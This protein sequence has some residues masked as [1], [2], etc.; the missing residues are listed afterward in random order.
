MT[1]FIPLHQSSAAATATK[2]KLAEG[3]GGD[4][5]KSRG[6]RR[7]RPRKSSG[8]C[9]RP[10][11]P[12]PRSGNTLPDR[13]PLSPHQPQ[14]HIL[15]PS[16]GTSFPTIE[17]PAGR[18]AGCPFGL[19]TT[20]TDGWWK[21]MLFEE[22]EKD[23]SSFLFLLPGAR[24]G[25]SICC[26]PPTLPPGPRS[27]SPRGRRGRGGRGTTICSK[28]ISGNGRGARGGEGGGERAQQNDEEEGG[29]RVRPTM[30]DDAIPGEGG[31]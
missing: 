26:P 15:S 27:A 7:P 25:C 11:M 5:S 2:T 3:D 31:T 17:W 9:V 21:R 4:E 13:S 23:P 30:D 24:P 10:S 12:P 8:L 16:G 1:K 28:T 6:C 14:Q 22:E 18:S 20:E 19:S 29:E